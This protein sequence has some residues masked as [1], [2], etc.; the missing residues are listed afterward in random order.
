[1]GDCAVKTANSN[2]NSLGFQ[3]SE[4]LRAN[5]DTIH[6]PAA[7]PDLISIRLST[8]RELRGEYVDAKKLSMHCDL[9]AIREHPAF[10]SSLSLNYGVQAFLTNGARGNVQLRVSALREALDERL[11]IAPP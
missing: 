8:E 3:R 9:Q 2:R 11:G 10:L 7:Y 1:M 4:E 5:A 6:L